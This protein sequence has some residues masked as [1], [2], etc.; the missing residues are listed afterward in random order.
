MVAIVE[1]TLTRVMAGDRSLIP[2]IESNAE[3]DAPMQTGIVNR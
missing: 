2:V 3:P 1:T